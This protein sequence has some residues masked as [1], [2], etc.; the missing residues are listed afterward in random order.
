[1]TESPHSTTDA[2]RGGVL[3]LSWLART[4]LVVLALSIAS[5]QAPARVKLLGLF[6]VVVGGAMGAASAFFTRPPPNR[7]CWQWLWA[8][9]LMAAGG[10]AGST[11]LAFRLD[12][13]SQPKSP[14]QQMAASMMKQMERDSGGEL[15]SAPTVS[16]VNEFRWYLARRVRQLGAWSSPWPEL[17]WCVELL[18]GGAAAAWGFRF[19]VAQTRGAA[20][21]EETSS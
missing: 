1:M 18:A 7:V 16:T 13:A 15:V 10:L 20:A 8:M 9:S 5:A 2:S 11:W 21:A 17:F 14:Q 4:A 6:S 19:G 3:W 12:A